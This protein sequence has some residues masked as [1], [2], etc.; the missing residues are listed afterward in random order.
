MI[1]I[2]SYLKI[3]NNFTEI[4]SYN[5]KLSDDFYIEGAL[6]IKINEVPIITTENWDLIDQLWSYLVD[7]LKSVSVNNSFQSY[8]PD[9]P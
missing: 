9:Q 1:F 5:G 3:E 2:K 8:F 4:D 6:V 7:G